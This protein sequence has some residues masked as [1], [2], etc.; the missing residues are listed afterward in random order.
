MT[1]YQWVFFDREHYYFSHFEGKTKEEASLKA[2]EHYQ[3]CID[4]I[5]AEDEVDNSTANTYEEFLSRDRHYIV[6]RWIAGI[7]CELFEIEI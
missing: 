6:C 5:N 2:W 3:Q 4:D 1:I 7:E